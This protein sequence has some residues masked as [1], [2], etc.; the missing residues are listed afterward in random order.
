MINKK[1]SNDVELNETVG[2][3]DSESC[4]SSIAICGVAAAKVTCHRVG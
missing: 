2:T 3:A 1:K 4:G